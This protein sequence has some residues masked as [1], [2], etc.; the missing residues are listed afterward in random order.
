MVTPAVMP[1]KLAGIKPIKQEVIT[2]FAVKTSHKAI[3]RAWKQVGEDAIISLVDEKTRNEL[4]SL[5]ER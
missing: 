2:R 3:R 1:A 5:I 4:F